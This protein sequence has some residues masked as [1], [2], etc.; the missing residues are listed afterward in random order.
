MKWNDGVADRSKAKVAY[1]PRGDR[2]EAEGETDYRNEKNRRLPVFEV[3]V[4]GFEPATPCLQSMCS[5]S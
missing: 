1:V 4:V 3:E 2:P 5:T